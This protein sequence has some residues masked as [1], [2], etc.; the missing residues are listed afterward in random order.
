MGRRQGYLLD[1]LAGGQT[2]PV[3]VNVDMFQWSPAPLTI[4]SWFVDLSLIA[5]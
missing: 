3:R 2:V 5:Y 4:F 1:R